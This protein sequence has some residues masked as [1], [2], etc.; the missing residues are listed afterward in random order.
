MQKAAVVGSGLIGAY[1]ALRLK[2][3]GLDVFS[4]TRKKKKKL[5]F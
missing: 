2:E 3:K 5:G 4:M 1:L